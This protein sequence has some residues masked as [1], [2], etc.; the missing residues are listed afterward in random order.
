MSAA[1]RSAHALDHAQPLLRA[2][3]VRRQGR[4]LDRRPV[5]GRDSRRRLP[6]EVAEQMLTGPSIEKSIAPLRSFVAEPMRFGRLFLVGDAAHIVP[7]TGAKGLNLAASRRALPLSR[8]CAN[9]YATSVDA[10]IDAY[11]AA[12][13]AA[14]LEGRALLLV[15]DHDAAPFPGDRHGFGSASRKPSS[16][17]WSI[18]ARPRRHWRKTMSDCHTEQTAH[19]STR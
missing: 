19:G 12:A 17:I 13:L 16:I 9:Y 10:G 1:L 7:P 6:A 18:R 11:S 3:S 14:G 2:V 15:D 8:R 5:L 4:G